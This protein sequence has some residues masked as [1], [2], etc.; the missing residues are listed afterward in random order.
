VLFQDHKAAAAAVPTAAATPA[1]QTSLPPASDSNSSLTSSRTQPNIPLKPVVTSP[2]PLRPLDR[3]PS[4]S[5]PSTRNRSPT[6]TAFSDL[7][8]QGNSTHLFSRI[9]I[10]ALLGKKQL[11]QL[12]GFLDKGN[13]AKDSLGGRSENMSLRA[14]RAKREAD[15]AGMFG[16][17]QQRE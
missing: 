15:E 3:R 1:P 10:I 12:I 7:A 6:T 4:G 16:Y 17:A 14:V 9:Q 5:S 8:H 2:Q 13:A 11:N